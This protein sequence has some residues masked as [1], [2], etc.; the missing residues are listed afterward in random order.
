MS[1]HL[2]F[3][4]MVTKLESFVESNKD[5]FD[6]NSIYSFINQTKLLRNLFNNNLLTSLKNVNTRLVGIEKSIMGM[7][8]NKR[9]DIIEKYLIELNT[10]HMKLLTKSSEEITCL[11]GEMLGLKNEIFLLKSFIEKQECKPTVKKS[12]KASVKKQTKKTVKKSEP[13]ITVTV[14]DKDM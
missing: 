13:N 12:R 3:N 11:K 9:L 14:S 10:K 7:N 5:K 4:N 6:S 8:T 1:L 2:D